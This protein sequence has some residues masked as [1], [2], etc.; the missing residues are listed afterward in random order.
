MNKCFKVIWN[1]AT[2][3]WQAVSEL[4]TSAKKTKSAVNLT[5]AALMVGVAGQAIAADPF[6]RTT[7]TGTQAVTVGDVYHYGTDTVLFVD[8]NA[9]A[10]I[11]GVNGETI[12]EFNPNRDRDRTRG[13]IT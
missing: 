10:T 4:A 1:H 6:P 7:L 11:N 13:A 2:Q 5:A 3:S 12:I 8:H 9:T